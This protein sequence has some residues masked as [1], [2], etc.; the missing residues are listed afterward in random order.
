M[1][2]ADSVAPYAPKPADFIRSV[3]DYLDSNLN[4]EEAGQAVE[5]AL[6]HWS[7]TLDLR[8]VFASFWEEVKDL[9]ADGR[10]DWAD[11]LR[12]L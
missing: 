3:S 12:D 11:R 1:V 9:F 8:P 4:K 7:S 5:A 10:D 2:R 6:R